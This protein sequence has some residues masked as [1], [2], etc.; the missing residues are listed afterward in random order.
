MENHKRIFEE[1]LRKLENCL[2]EFNCKS[3]IRVS[4]QDAILFGKFSNDDERYRIVIHVK[5]ES[6]TPVTI[7]ARKIEVKKEEHKI[8][9]MPSL[10]LEQY[11]A[12]DANC[13]ENDQLAI[14]AKFEKE[15]SEIGREFLR[16]LKG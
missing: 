1:L 16:K 8:A 7:G 13:S 3:E 12:T 11:K 2:E 5:E 4:E 14:K 9:I 10:T 6:Y 15:A